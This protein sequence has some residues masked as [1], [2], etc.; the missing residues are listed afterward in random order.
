MDFL[1]SWN[2]MPHL[3]LLA[4]L[5]ILLVVNISSAHNG[6]CESKEVRPEIEFLNGIF[7]R[8]FWA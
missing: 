3:G 4:K 5:S 7:S 2:G 1:M 8:G 6:I